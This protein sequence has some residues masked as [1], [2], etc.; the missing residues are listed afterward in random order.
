ML[1]VSLAGCTRANDPQQ[2]ALAGEWVM[3]GD[4]LE[5]PLACG[6]HGPITYRS[7]GRYFIWGESGTWRLDGDVLSETLTS[8]DALH[9]DRSTADIGKPMVST[10]QWIDRARFSKRFADGSTNEFR[11]C[12]EIR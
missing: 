11:R 2:P 3:M 12:P 8:V 6:S 4:V 9:G 1:L 7:D 5:Y 10:I